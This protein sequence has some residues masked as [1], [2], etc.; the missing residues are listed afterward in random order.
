MAQFSCLPAPRYTYASPRNRLTGHLY[1]DDEDGDGRTEPDCGRGRGEPSRQRVAWSLVTEQPGHPRTWAHGRPSIG[2]AKARL[3][4]LAFARYVHQGAPR[5]SSTHLPTP[6]HGRL[7]RCL[8]RGVVL[9]I[10]VLSGAA[11]LIYEIVWSRQLVLVFGNTT[12]AVSAILT[13]FFGGMAIGAAVGGRIADRVRSPLRLY[14]VLELVLVVVVL[15]TPL[16][17]GLIHEVYRGI[18][19]ALEGTPFLA[20]ARLVLAVL[21]LAPATVMMG[22]TFPALVRHL[23]RT[24]E[25][26]QAFGRLYAANTL[27]AVAGTLARRPRPDRAARA[28]RRARGSG[29]LCSGIAGLVALWLAR[30]DA[31]RPMPPRRRAAPR[32][33][34]GRGSPGPPPPADGPE[35]DRLAAARRRL[36]LRA[37]LARLPGHLDPAARVGHRR[38]DLRLHGDPRAVPDRHRPRGRDLQ[39]LPAADRGSRPGPRDRRSPSRSSRGRPDPRDRRSRASLDPARP[40]E[41]VGALFGSAS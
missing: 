32:P 13:G 15:V 6:A 33:A 37:D 18:Y 9:A 35:P 12:Q 3:R 2:T 40:L 22:A 20:L 38:H 41:S 30:G 19:P 17:F 27:G 34:A 7:R 31:G 1:I 36:R 16:T 24:A 21:A 10:F 25:L 28:D 39:R 29:P 11:G 23:T 8:H 4:A 14:G 26:S 5:S